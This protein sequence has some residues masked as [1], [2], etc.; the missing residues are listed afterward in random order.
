MTRLDVRLG[1]AFCTPAEVLGR[2]VVVID[3]LRAATTVATALANG[4]RGVHPF[5]TVEETARRGAEMDRETVRLAGERRMVRIPGFDFGN[6]P[7][8]FTTDAIGKRTLLF[9]TTNGTPALAATHGARCCY[10][11]AFVNVA[12]TV[13]AVQREYAAKPADLLV[14]CA[15]HERHVTLEDIVC[16]GRIVRLLTSATS[17]EAEGENGAA[18]EPMFTLDDG[19]QIAMTLEAPYRDSLGALGNDAAHARALRAA[20]FG[21]DVDYSLTLDSVPVAVAF[22]GHRLEL[23]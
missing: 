15:G 14:L 10:F 18:S 11:A 22:K 5:E 20:G 17:G 19:A 8:E 7:L 23:H 3:V 21:A 13:A 6:S 2:I 12:A 4:A 16:A 1:E 9:T